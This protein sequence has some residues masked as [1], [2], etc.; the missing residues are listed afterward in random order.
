MARFHLSR[1]ALAILSAV[2]TAA[3]VAGILLIVAGPATAKEFATLHPLAGTVEVSK[4]GSDGFSAGSEGQTL[5]QGDTVRTG[6]DGRAE[7]EYFDGSVTRL[8][9]DTTYRLVELAS[10][11][12]VPDS[13]VIRGEQTGGRTFNRVVALTDSESRVETETPNAVASVQGTE[14]VVWLHPDGS[15]EYWVLEGEIAVKTDDGREI[16]VRAGEGLRVIGNQVEGPFPLTELQLEDAFLVFIRCEVDGESDDCPTEVE[17]RVERRDRGEDQESPPPTPPGGGTSVFDDVDDTDDGDGDGGGGTSIFEEPDPPPGPQPD[18]IDRRPVRFTLS[19]SGVPSDL[20]LHVSTPDDQDAEG[21]EVW[22][23]NA[24]LTG[25]DGCWA[26]ASGDAVGGGSETV[27]L[28]PIGD[29]WL[30]GGYQIWVENTS[31]EDGD[32]ADSNAVVTVSKGDDTLIDIPVPA[33]GEVRAETWRVA[34]AGIDS[35]GFPAVLMGDP[36]FVGEPV[37]GEPEE[38]ELLRKNPRGPAGPD[39]Q[40]ISVGEP[41]ADEVPAEEPPAEEPPSEEPP[42]SPEPS[43]APSSEPEPSPEPTEPPAAGAPAAGAAASASG[44]SA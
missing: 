31:C 36:H 12:D 8:D 14:Y 25:P 38:I 9:F 41:P 34:S 2:V 37:C 29:E 28:R 32:W 35:E 15:E 39:T 1:R 21:G 43:P 42:P 22:W 30:R 18:P 17:P 19:W 6:P 23:G 44:E 20:D 11:T 5:R 27:V 33:E 7:I 4:A 10:M 40:A 26:T 24:C 3:L 13:K 16:V